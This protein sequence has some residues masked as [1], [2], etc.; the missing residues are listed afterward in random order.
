MALS[1]EAVFAWDWDLGII[2]WNAG[3]ERQYG[4]TRAE[5]LSKNSHELLASKHP[6]SLRRF[7]KKLA[8]DGYWAGEVR[9][10]TKDGKELIVD[11]RQQVI[12]RDGR[13][14]VI[15]SNRDISERRAG[16]S[17]IAIL[18]VIGDLIRT[19]NDPDELLYATAKTVGVY[20]NARRCVFSEID[21]ENDLENIH[22]DYHRSGRSVAGRHK[23]SSYSP[24]TLEEMKAGGVVR[25][26]DSKVD[27]R[28]ADL[29][30]KVYERTGERSYVA[31]PLMRDGQWK[32]TLWISDDQPREWSEAGVALLEVL[33]ERVWL[34]V[35]KHRSEE[36]LRASRAQLDLIVTGTPFML[37]LCSSDLRYKYVSRSYAE[38]LA[39][40][41]EDLVGMPIIEMIGK[42]GFETIRPFIEAVLRG[43][44]VEF[45]DE[46]SFPGVGS[47]H[48]RV[49]YVP[50]R[51]HENK[52]VGWIASI[53]DISERVRSENLL[54]ESEE[55]YRILAEAASDAIL[56][57]DESSTIGF[58]NTAATRIFGYAEK[59]MAGQ[60]LTMLM[61]EKLR[62]QHRAGFGRYLK[63]GVKKL[64]WENVHITARHKDGR[65]FPIEISFGEYNR[66]G[67]RFFIGIARDVTEQKKAIEALRESEQRRQ[68]AQDAGKIGIFDADLIAG[69][70]YWSETMWSLYGEAD[71][72]RNPD[73]QYWLAHLHELDRDR[74]KR[75][76]FSVL[77]NG[78]DYRD[79]YRIIQPNGSVK[80]IE[81]R[82]KVVR[83]ASG[84]AVRK[85]GVNMD[86]TSRKEAEEKIQQ[87][88]D[89]LRLV[90]DSVP[91]LISYVDKNECYRFANE[92]FTDWFGIPKDE[93][94]GKQPRDV[95][96]PAAYKILKP[97]INDALAGKKC[98]FDTVLSYNGIDEKHVSVS[99]IPDFGADG[100]VNGYYGLTHD[101]TALQ[102]SEDLVRS[103]NER[104][105]LITDSFTD[106]AIFSMDKNGIIETWNPGAEIIFGYSREDVLGRSYEFVF[107]PEDLS[108][109]VWTKEMRNSRLKGRSFYEGWRLRKDGSRF[110]ASAVMMPLYV[111][112]TLT[113][114]S[115]IVSDVTQKK[116][117]A[118]ELQKAHDELEIRVEERT[119]ELAE[120]NSALIEEMRE[121]EIAEKQRIELLGRLVSS[122]EFERRRFA[123]DLHDQMGQRL[124]ALRLKL[125]SLHELV[126]ADQKITTRINR[127]EAIAEQLDS[128]VSFLAWELRPAALDD[129]GVLEAIRTFV[130]EW[131]RHF[132]IS[133]D[134]HPSGLPGERLERDVETHL[135]RITQEAL[136]NIAKHAEAKHV[137]VLLEKRE[138]NIML[139]IEDDGNGFD[140]KENRG[141]GEYGAGLGLTGMSER[142]T[143]I[144][145]ELEIESAPGKG[146]T[147]YVRL[148]YLIST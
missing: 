30:K 94:I 13:K 24:I 64:N 88:D 35:E 32:A 74:V 67:K 37:T 132:E 112:K 138:Q 108:R 43:E 116:R 129:L 113:G 17:Q 8:T 73:E 15:E 134:F 18:I 142:A 51:D 111:G 23:L 25:N 128:E 77:E 2:E 114:Y 80:W 144:G 72:D 29:Y 47:R 148:P 59:E 56:S 71:T 141:A 69:K 120:L 11:S 124:T 140:L 50:E 34:A 90:T 137:T 97:W 40:R 16:E 110:F 100:T 98:A 104:I 123:R 49:S 133:A 122:Q 1:H 41:P 68:L 60:P 95:F 66:G 33:A 22:R 38:M 20:F 101:R 105:G 84:K 65:H 82:A 76:L 14:I 127:L 12:S 27:P 131:S 145:G 143:L 57:I 102:H 147:I 26:A 36:S 63:T 46:V 118:E 79:E 4:F 93:V 44:K 119:K 3:A 78:E 117:Q 21:L 139:I 10:T 54:R 53:V 106:Y 87:G 52:V 31:V 85:Y 103:T 96:G 125:A 70:T 9:H 58:V 92:T 86:I 89:Q 45:E 28:T 19:I 121:R 62:P 42:D 61:P 81:V 115:K 126:P 55:S 109:G 91:V 5:A 135:Y 75:H 39:R 146:T 107:T 6:V 83:D 48:L 7:L 99:Y 130:S 136:N